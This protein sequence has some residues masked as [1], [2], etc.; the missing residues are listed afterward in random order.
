MK[1]LIDLN[2]LLDVVQK[3]EPHYAASAAVL[4]CVVRKDVEACLPGHALTT[5]HYVVGR[6]RDRKKADEVVDWLLGAFDVVG[7]GK[8]EFLRARRLPMGDFEDAVVASAAERG[9]CDCVVTRNV[10]DFRGSPVRALTPEEF[11][12][13]L[14]P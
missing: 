7:E 14:T 12:G 3:R 8:E 5:I 10:A 13:V 1:V 2:V 6:S 4:S 9:G 11:L